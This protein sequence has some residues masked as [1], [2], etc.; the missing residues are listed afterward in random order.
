MDRFEKIVAAD[1]L[2]IYGLSKRNRD[3]GLGV[4]FI[5]VGKKT[6]DLPIKRSSPGTL[7]MRIDGGIADLEKGSMKGKLELFAPFDRT[8]VEIHGKPVP[9]ESDL[10]AQLAYN[11]NQPALWKLDITGFFLGKSPIPTGLYLT[12]PFNPKQIPVV[13]V[14]G[15]ASS[16]VWW[17]EMANTFIR[18]HF[19]KAL[20]VLVLFLRQRQNHRSSPPITLEKH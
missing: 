15:T 1:R 18:T 20:S 6:A 12:K 3:A 17:A 4:A 11:L 2:D 5:A 10:S 7:F 16:P 19:E 8:H 9:L 14:H 13:F